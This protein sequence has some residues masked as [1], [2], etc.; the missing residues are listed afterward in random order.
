MDWSSKWN[1]TKEKT[2]EEGQEATDRQQRKEAKG[3]W[4]EGGGQIKGKGLLAD[5]LKY[6][7][8]FHNFSYLI[9]AALTLS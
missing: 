9:D 6:S 3:K 2:K 7:I 5:K 1:N 4:N 8:N